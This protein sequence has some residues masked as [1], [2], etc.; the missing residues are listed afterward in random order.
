MS[1]IVALAS[2]M[3]AAR[4]APPRTCAVI[5]GGIAGL[6]CARRLEELGIRATVFDTGRTAPGGRAS[7]RSLRLPNGV[8]TFDHAAQFFTAT[9]AFAEL[10][11][12][13]EADGTIRRWDHGLGELNARTGA[14][15]EYA[16]HGTAGGADRWIGARSMRDVS[17]ALARGLDVRQGVWV[18]P[19]GGITR[20]ADDG[21]YVVRAGGREL[22]AYDA[23][24]VAHNGK[25]AERLSRGAGSEGVHRLLRARFAPALRAA[26]PADRLVL[27]SIFSLLAVLP[28]SQL[29]GSRLSADL[30]GARVHGSAELGFV[31]CH[32]RK[33]PESAAALAP[34]EE[35]WSL[36]STAAFGAAHKAPQEAMPPDVVADVTAKLLAAFGAAVGARAPLAPT[37]T[38][39]QLW[40]AAVPLNV[41]RA[42]ADTCG[43]APAPARACALDGARRIGACGD[44]LRAPSVQ[45]AWESGVALADALADARA[46]AGGVP[47]GRWLPVAALASDPGAAGFFVDDTEPPARGAA[48]VPERR[49]ARRD[50]NAR[51]PHGGARRAPGG[52]RAAAD[53][54][55][56]A[57]V[58]GLPPGATEAD[59]AE[60]VRGALGEA[61]GAAPRDAIVRASLLRRDDGPA[62]CGIVLLRSAALLD[63]LLGA[64]APEIAGRRLH[65]ERARSA[66]ARERRIS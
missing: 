42:D 37:R 7:S 17:A 50:A 38:H 26:Q 31:V 51:A 23:I 60:C 55:A 29:A 35:A 54:P 53:A 59:L 32:T 6:A 25:C 65:V 49:A 28:R 3:A 62:R 21:R 34:D 61:T 43:G 36:F 13:W 9:G 57:F 64:R 22:G 46:D 14:F 63:A 12:G 18:S 5:G 47:A 58:R 19:D 4:V 66:A 2:S 39:L 8:L 44:W 52:A 1:A 27:N 10:A 11:R 16:R 30:G 40:G 45:G 56:R 15:V 33:R 24:A 20:R 41:W 48:L